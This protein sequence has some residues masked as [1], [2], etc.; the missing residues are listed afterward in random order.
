MNEKKKAKTTKKKKRKIR[1]G[2]VFFALVF[3]ILVIKFSSF[4]YKAPIKNIVIKGNSFF[5][6]QEIIDLAGIRDYP[7]SLQNLSVNIEKKLEKNTYI[8]KAEVD[9]TFSGTVNIEIE[10]NYPLFYYQ[11]SKKTVLSN[12]LEVSSEFAIPF[13]ANYIPNTIYDDFLEEM[14]KISKD[15]LTRISEIKYNPN[16]VDDG[17]FLLSMKDGNYVYL[18]LSR[19]SLI[20]HYIEIISQEELK[21]KK[22]IIKLD[23][24]N[25]FEILEG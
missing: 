11:P 20:D 22:G 8:I 16:D 19:F 4:C 23:A 24:G 7:S 5:N 3:V 13:V 1:Y 9:K 6:D 17:R 15:V 12:G 14:G 2:R 18:T 25:S 21:G 10:E